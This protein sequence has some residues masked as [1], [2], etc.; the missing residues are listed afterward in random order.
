M[1]PS[2]PTNEVNNDQE[3]QSAQPQSPSS[4]ETA[5]P[6]S[7]SG[8]P[9]A[10]PQV[11]NNDNANKANKPPAPAFDQPYAYTTVTPQTLKRPFEAISQDDPSPP[12]SVKP[13]SASPVPFSTPASAAAPY[14]A[15]SGSAPFNTDAADGPAGG[16]PSK[17]RP[18]HCLKC[19]SA[20]CKGKGGR[21]LC[22]NPCQDCG[23]PDCQGR[24]RPHKTCT[25]SGW[26]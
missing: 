21:M 25:E 11:P 2:A 26:P 4:S 13:S 10:Y 3:Q 23:L 16:E 19:G 7:P 14:S 18:R 22:T 6:F 20:D 9:S 17:R 5:N 24:R 8:T 15:A 12:N 1:T